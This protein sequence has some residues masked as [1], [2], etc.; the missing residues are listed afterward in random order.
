V[1]VKIVPSAS[2]RRRNRANLTENDSERVPLTAERVNYCF[3]CDLEGKF[4]YFLIEKHG[5]IE[6]DI[7]LIRFHPKDGVGRYVVERQCTQEAENHK[8]KQTFEE[9]LH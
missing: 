1:N 8:E 3:L 5:D 7:H 9:G 4:P 2:K 6:F